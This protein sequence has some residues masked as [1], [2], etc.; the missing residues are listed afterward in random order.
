VNRQTRILIVD[1]GPAVAALLGEAWAE[2]EGPEVHHLARPDRLL[3]VLDEG[4]PYDL[5]VAGPSEHDADGRSRIAVAR[6]Q[7]LVAAVVTAGGTDGDIAGAATSDDARRVIEDVLRARGRGIVTAVI[8]VSGGAGRTTVALSLADLVA[9]GGERAAVV[10]ASLQFGAVGTALVRPALRTIADVLYDERGREQDAA[11][12]VETLTD[13]ASGAVANLDGFAVLAAPGDPVDADRIG[14]EQ[15]TRVIAAMAERLDRVV[16]DTAAGLGDHALAVLDIADEVVIVATLDVPG[17]AALRAVDALLDQLGIPAPAR[18]LLLNKELEGTGL[19]GVQAA[20]ALGRQVAGVVPFDP[21]I[22]RARNHG[23]VATTLPGPGADALRMALA[24]V[25]P[26]ITAAQGA[27]TPL[28]APR[29][30]SRPWAR[31]AVAA[32]EGTSS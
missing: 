24:T 9:R 26:S 31:A 20:Q 6:E 5:L 18:H 8:G 2:G 30:L 3:D 27:I 19:P 11:T 10:D 13:L 25:A 7:G 4:A 1:R 17:M 23:R 21:E 16:V 14:P 28:A 29:R 22:V 32:G 12:V 15:L